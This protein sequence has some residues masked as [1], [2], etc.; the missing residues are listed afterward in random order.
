MLTGYTLAGK[1]AHDD[2]PDGMAMAVLYLDG[3]M[4]GKVEVMKRPW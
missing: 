3:M 1:N 4:R 2:V